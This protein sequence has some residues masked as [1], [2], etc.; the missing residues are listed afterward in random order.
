M[1]VRAEADERNEHRGF[2]VTVVRVKEIRH[3]ESR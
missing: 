2:Q 3:R 1:V